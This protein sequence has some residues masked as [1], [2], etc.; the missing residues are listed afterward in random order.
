MYLCKGNIFSFINSVISDA[1]ISD[2]VISDAVISDA[3]SIVK[4]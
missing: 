4:S 3:V 1:V 2:A